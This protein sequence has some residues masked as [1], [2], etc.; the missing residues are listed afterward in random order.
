MRAAGFALGARHRVRCHQRKALAFEARMQYSVL[1]LGWNLVGDLAFAIRLHEV[2]LGIQERCVELHRLA[3]IAGEV[4]VAEEHN[5]S[6]VFRMRGCET[7]A[8]YDSRHRFP[9]RSLA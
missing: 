9:S 5:R 6:V 8:R 3:A 2:D 1:M 7:S 4:E